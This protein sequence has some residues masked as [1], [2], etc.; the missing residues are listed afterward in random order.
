MRAKLDGALL[1]ACSLLERRMADVIR[2]KFGGRRHNNSDWPEFQAQETGEGGEPDIKRPPDQDLPDAGKD[3]PE[4]T[5]DSGAPP[6]TGEDGEDAGH[7]RP[8]K[9]DRPTM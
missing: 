3:L 1:A 7:P 2:G 4:V 6:F 8:R 9:R 5:D